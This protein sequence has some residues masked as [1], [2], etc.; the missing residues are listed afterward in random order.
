MVHWIGNDFTMWAKV[1]RLFPLEVST[2]HKSSNLADSSFLRTSLVHST[3]AVANA[4]VFSCLAT[5]GLIWLATVKGKTMKWI[6][7]LSCILTEFSITNRSIR[8]SFQMEEIDYPA[9]IATLFARQLPPAKVEDFTSFYNISTYT[10]KVSIR[11]YTGAPLCRFSN[12]LNL[13]QHLPLSTYQSPALVREDARLLQSIGVEFIKTRNPSSYPEGEILHADAK[14]VVIRL[15]DTLPRVYLAK[16][17][18]P[19]GTSEFAL[20][21]LLDHSDEDSAA[22]VETDDESLRI[23]FQDLEKGETATISDY[24]ATSVKVRV[25][26]HSER[27]V[28]LSE[29][30]YPSWEASVPCQLYL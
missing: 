16:E 9:E 15:K 3:H 30:Y 13:M 6:L 25:N 17:V 19:A 23:P 10:E 26:T 4:L 22:I 11:G 27:I 21:Y 18:R 12:Y 7:I 1:L 20:A 14:G 29:M 28:V 8:G 24:S 2:I 5:A